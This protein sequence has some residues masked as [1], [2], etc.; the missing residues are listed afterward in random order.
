MEQPTDVGEF[1]NSS[2]NRDWR[3]RGGMTAMP[4][5]DPTDQEIDDAI[6]QWRIKLKDLPDA[7][8]VAR[9]RVD[10]RWE[11]FRQ[12]V[13]NRIAEGKS[14]SE[15]V[16]QVG[17]P[18]TAVAAFRAHWTQGYRPEILAGVEPSPQVDDGQS[19]D[20]VV[21]TFGL[22]R[23]LQRELRNNLAQLEPDLKI[24]DDGREH[25]CAA[26]LIDILCEDP[27]G[28]LVVIELKAGLAKDAA[29][30][31]VLGY[32]GAITREL[33]SE[34]KYAD[35]P[36]RGIMVAKDFSDRVRHA[37]VAVPNLR[38]VSYAIQFTF[39]DRSFG[40]S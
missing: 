39:N 24:I 31:Q 14:T 32:M 36:V 37:S 30:G 18:A 21:T 25:G 29:L 28:A 22:E 26:G 35:R 6:R 11:W 12:E 20:A 27:R 4:E 40:V 33:A 9:E 15:I 34:G 13:Y 38:L 7:L 5:T 23:D 1:G 2:D 19:E 17:L 16:E 3:E 10:E 8:G